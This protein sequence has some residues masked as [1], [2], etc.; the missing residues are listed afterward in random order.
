MTRSD[1]IEFHFAGSGNCT[2]FFKVIREAMS[3]E[4]LSTHFTTFEWP[5]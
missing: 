3:M 1:P 5:W 2:R 4:K